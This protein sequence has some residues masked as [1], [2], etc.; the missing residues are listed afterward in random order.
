M[1]NIK[2]QWTSA[3]LLYMKPEGKAVVLYE[4]TAWDRLCQCLAQQPSG[5]TDSVI[6]YM[7]LILP[8]QHFSHHTLVFYS[9]ITKILNTCFKTC[10]LY[11]NLLKHEPW[12]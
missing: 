2:T 10:L 7:H 1:S 6:P 11:C 9:S 12:A 8:V 5:P 4:P 3:L